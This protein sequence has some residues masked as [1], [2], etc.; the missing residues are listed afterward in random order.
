LVES[1]A[2][3]AAAKATARAGMESAYVILMP[4]FRVNH[5]VRGLP[6]SDM[7]RVWYCHE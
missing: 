6:A 1:C 4:F 3:T 5:W 7:G 2:N